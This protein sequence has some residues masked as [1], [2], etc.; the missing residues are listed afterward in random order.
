MCIVGAGLSGSVL[1]ERHATEFHHKV[2]LVEKRNHIGGNVYD[3]ID[4]ET[5][6]RV[7]LYGMH[8]FHT[9]HERVK[10]Y[11]ERFSEW[12][13]YEHRVLARVGDKHVPVPVNIDT[14]NELF[15]L[16][17]SSQQEMEEWLQKNQIP[18]PSGQATNSEQ[19][20]LQRV[21]RRLY[22]LIFKP[23]TIKQW[24]KDP[25]E[26]GPSVL[27]RIPVRSN[28]DDRYFTDPFQAL[29]TD[30]YT[31]LFENMLTSSPNIKVKLNT[32][33]FHVRDTLQCHHTYFTGPIDAYYAAKGLP[34]LQY[35]SLQFEQ[36]IVRN[37]PG[38][39]LP[40]AVVNHPPLEYNFTRVAEYK[41]LLNQTSNHTVLV[42]ER[43]SDV[44]EPYYPVPNEKN[45]ELYAKYQK[46]ASQERGVSFVGRLA[47]VQVL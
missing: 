24:N 14:V 3:Y 28:H 31:K 47:S 19:V 29:P 11:V 23:Y 30:G 43:S 37:V 41:H 42:Y 46:M 17:I 22:D 4:E 25:K 7:S 34:K 32:D 6:I 35:R 27:A 13:P 21:G 33:Y 45:H 12:M 10:E 2:L 40:A 38:F 16:S 15:D 18:P 20:G 5:G 9:N 44:G 39:Y 36:K 26:L 8:L 1:A